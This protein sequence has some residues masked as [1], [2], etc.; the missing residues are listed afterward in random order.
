MK[1]NKRTILSKTDAAGRKISLFE[2]YDE[3]AINQGIFVEIDG[4]AIE[5]SC[6][7]SAKTFYNSIH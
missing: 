7:S 1:L 3:T 6:M 2:K 4:E 5:Y